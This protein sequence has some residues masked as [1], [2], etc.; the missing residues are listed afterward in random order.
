MGRPGM[1][2]PGGQLPGIEVACGG[3]HRPMALETCVGRVKGHRAVAERHEKRTAGIE[4][5]AS[6]LVRLLRTRGWLPLEYLGAIEAA[7]VALTKGTGWR[8]SA[9]AG[10]ASLC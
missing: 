5:L 3:R 6:S 8:G 10:A 7:L 1:T 2:M 4:R 9:S